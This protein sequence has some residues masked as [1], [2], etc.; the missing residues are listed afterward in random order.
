MVVNV[1]SDNLLNAAA[2]NG[3]FEDE[4]HEGQFV[5]KLT[6]IRGIASRRSEQWFPRTLNIDVMFFYSLQLMKHKTIAH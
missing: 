4:T 1:S 5:K 6:T 2:V 3:N